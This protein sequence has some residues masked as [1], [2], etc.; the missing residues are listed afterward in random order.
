VALTEQD[1]DTLRSLARRIDPSD[2]GA[3]NNLGVLYYLKDLTAES[4]EQFSHAL[5]L[6][7]RMSVAE[8]NL[9]L[10]YRRSGHYDRR[11]QELHAALRADPE[12][13]D[14]RWELGRA[15]VSLAQYE[16]AASEFQALVARNPDDVAATVQL[17][18]AEKKVGNLESA[19]QWLERARQMEPDSSVI[20]FYLGEVL[21]NRGLNS[22]ALETLEHAIELSPDYAD[23]HHLLAF[24]LGDVGR[25]EDARIA[26][27]RAI[28]LNPTYGRAQ[29]NLS[30]E[31]MTGDRRSAGFETPGLEAG[32]TGQEALPHH[33]LGLAFRRQG[34]Y[35]EALREYRLA[36]DR[37]EDRRFVEQG[38]AEV[39]L[40]QR[41]HAA[42]LDLYDGLVRDS[43]ESPKFWNE[44]GVVLHQL[45][46]FQDA[47]ESY[48]KAIERD[49]SYALPHNNLAIVLAQ[50]GKHDQAVSE[51]KT[52]VKSDPGMIIPQLNLGLL[53]FKLRRFQLALET[54]RKVLEKHPVTGAW[55]GIG[56]V[57]NE[58][59]RPKDARNAFA[60]AV[61]VGPASAEAHYNLSFALSRLGDFDGAL[62]AVTRAQS[63][64]PYYVPQKFR[65]AIDM[66]FE[67]PGIAVVPEISADVTADVAHPISF[68]QSQIDDMFAELDEAPALQAPFGPTDPLA[69]A[70]DYLNKGLLDLAAAE[71]DRAAGRGVDPVEMQILSGD[72]YA[73]RGLHGEALERYR[74]AQAQAPNRWEA[75]MG[76]I[77][78]LLALGRGAD[79]VDDAASLAEE[80]PDNVDVLVLLAEARLAAGDPANALEYLDRARGRAPQRADILKLEGDIAADMGDL[81]AAQQAYEGALDLEPRLAQVRVDLGRLHEARND[82]KAAEQSYRAA[83]ETLPTLSEAALALARVYRQGDMPQMAVNLLIEALK[84]DPSDV[85]SLLALG[86]SLLEDGRVEH[87]VEAFERVLAFDDSNV[88]AHFYRGVAAAKQRRYTE[89]LR[90]WELVVGIEPDGPFA[91]EARKHARSALDLKHIF[92]A[93]VA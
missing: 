82:L 8:R 76:A 92:Q 63:L 48:L 78:Q 83:L 87:A 9:E 65:L 60:R 21:Y 31:R 70:R 22:E 73:R 86:Q 35:K 23:A 6:D 27:K 74:A 50:S 71:S 56:L 62:R 20:Y 55:N 1:R 80:H 32:D 12:N 61:E 79:A 81:D 57:L 54:Y 90:E 77:R 49:A 26:T 36:L 58:M 44:R 24:V 15:Y 40:L 45:G 17:A 52:A 51:L 68:D 33:N 41:D 53:L 25:H 29:T 18:L 85:D 46:R 3:H 84:S 2:A 5:A 39:F 16:A 43:P 91:R 14:A 67:D 7:P 19:S 88:G 13:R 28:E 93:R 4:V 42:A 37:G 47:K 64:D 10:A 11:V 66:Q 30:L 69:L 72:I 89:A 38:M 59:G 75:R 34:Y